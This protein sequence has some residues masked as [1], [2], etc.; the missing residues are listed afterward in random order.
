MNSTPL[1][2]KNIVKL[3]A[4]ICRDLAL[5][6]DS[7]LDKLVKLANSVDKRDVTPEAFYQQLGEFLQQLQTS[8]LVEISNYLQYHRLDAPLL[9]AMSA[10]NLTQAINDIIKN[11]DIIFGDGTKFRCIVKGKFALATV[12]NPSAYFSQ[13]DFIFDV[14]FVL[15]LFVSRAV[16]G[17]KFDV[18]QLILPLQ[19][20]N[21]PIDVLRSVSAANIEFGKNSTYQFGFS[22]DWLALHSITHDEP[23]RKRLDVE[24]DQRKAIVRTG[25]SF[26]EKVMALIK[27]AKSPANVTL[28]TV[29]DSLGISE[30]H[31]RKKLSEENTSFKYLCKWWLLEE[32]ISKLLSSDTKIDVIALELGYSERAPFERAFKS[33]LGISPS[34]FRE[35]S[36][37]FG[38]TD[39]TAAF[40]ARVEA[41]PPLP[42]SCRRLLQLPEEQMT[43]DDVVEIVE[44]DPVFIARLTGLASRAVFGAR[45]K[46]IREAIG[47]NLGIEKV[48]QLALL[49]SVKDLLGNM[50][51][52]LDVDA[53]IKATMISQ[54]I[55]YRCQ[56]Q[57][58]FD[59]NQPTDDYVLSMGL[60]GMFLMF[61]KDDPLRQE[62]SDIYNSADNFADFMSKAHATL[63]VSVYKV[64]GI[65]LAIWGVNEDVV[66]ELTIQGDLLKGKSNA[67]DRYLYRILSNSIA[68]STTKDTPITSL[69]IDMFEPVDEAVEISNLIEYANG[70]AKS[71]GE[72]E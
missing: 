43:L 25:I 8:P 28:T 6:N 54:M 67:D 62:L 68:M 45:P 49:F 69:D 24:I 39:R 4:V 27:Q 52:N 3:L 31:A 26:S 10:E 20:Q 13:W 61:H 51:E 50:V 33:N 55:Y 56:R 70:V 63:N 34:Q 7:E 16:V 22:K 60:L 5:A 53:L 42:S 32:A 72:F 29:A 64:S 48:R 47:R 59:G 38:N 2:W 57:C 1:Y 9:H 14:V 21:K 23:E 71:I 65:M 46:N 41:L 12:S 66:K 18:Q 58:K 37:R 36:L 15:F 30:S 44:T 19:R 35:I 17:K 40:R 11:Q